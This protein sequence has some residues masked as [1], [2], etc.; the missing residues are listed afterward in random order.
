MPKEQDPEKLR[1][2]I[3]AG[4]TREQ[5]AD[6]LSRQAEYDT[7]LAKQPKKTGK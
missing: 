5:A 2:K 6:V 1:N 7:L 4:L 3:K